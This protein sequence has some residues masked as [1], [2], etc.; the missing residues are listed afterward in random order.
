[1]PKDKGKKEEEKMLL[2]RLPKEL[3]RQIRVSLRVGATC[4]ET[5]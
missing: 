4:Y 5:G 3:H 1:M 2:V